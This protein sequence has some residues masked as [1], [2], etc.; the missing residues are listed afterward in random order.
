MKQEDGFK[1]IHMSNHK[2]TY[3]E[4]NIEIIRFS[5]FN[6]ISGDIRIYKK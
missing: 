3:L 2:S 6:N 5:G 1:I 4:R